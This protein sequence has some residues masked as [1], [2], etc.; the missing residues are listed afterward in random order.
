MKSL[1]VATGVLRGRWQALGGRERNL[2]ATALGVVGLALL[3]WVMLA[4][5]LR[6]VRTAPEQHRALDAQREQML[7][8]SAQ[9]KAFQAQPKLGYDEALKALQAS[10]TQQLGGAGQIN[11]AGERV[12]VTLKGVRPEALAQWLVQSRS[13][14]RALATEMRLTKSA[15]GWDGTVVLSLPAR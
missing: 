4:P 5:A 6:V 2:V 8:L 13:N 3:W 11:V 10:V 1:P 7:A 9:A 14:A 15:S 12:S